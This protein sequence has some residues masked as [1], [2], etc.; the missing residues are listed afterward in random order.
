MGGDGG[1]TPRIR[2][3]RNDGS[4]CRC[5]VSASCGGP[6][7]ACGSGGAKDSRGEWSF[8]EDLS[9]AGPRQWTSRDVP[10]STDVF[11]RV[12]RADRCLS[13]AAYRFTITR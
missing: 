2:L 13:C 10:W 1:G 6:P 5:A 8:V 9:I 4:G 12:T 3:T 11:V 7:L